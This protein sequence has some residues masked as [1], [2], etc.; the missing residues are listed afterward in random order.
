MKFVTYEV[1]TPI[2]AVHRVGIPRDDSYIDLTA[3]YEQLLVDDGVCRAQEIAEAVAPPDMIDLLAGGSRSIEAAE[4]VDRTSFDHLSRAPSGAR[5]Q[6]D[7]EEVSLC[8]PLPRP[9]TIRDFSVFENHGR[10]DKPDVWYELPAG[11][12]GNPDSVVSPGADVEWPAYDDSPD[13]ELEIGAVIGKRGTNISAEDASNYIAGY[14]IFNDFS[15]RDIQFEEMENGLG[16]MKGKDF[17]NGFGPVLVTPDEFD[18]NN[19]QA[20]VYV[21]GEKWNS[22]NVGDMYHSFDDLVEHASSHEPIQP[23]DVIG[24]GTVAGCCCFDMD[25]WIDY[26][27]TVELEVEG[28]GTLSHRIVSSS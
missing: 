21:N 19:A 6:Y 4:Q 18:P 12:K 22:N 28:I 3:A 23:G 15:A 20:T 17:A 16:P 7:S 8:S 27:D 13:F 11:Y 1:D 24:S 25:R 9:N 26:G 10:P 14:T 5:I 2:G